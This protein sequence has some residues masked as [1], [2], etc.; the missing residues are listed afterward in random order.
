MRSFLGLVQRRKRIC[1]DHLFNYCKFDWC[2]AKEFGGI[3][4]FVILILI[5]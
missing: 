3:V 5:Q 4:I 2:Q 1:A